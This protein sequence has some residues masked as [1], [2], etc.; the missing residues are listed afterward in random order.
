VHLTY[1][2]KGI[3]RKERFEERDR[4]RRLLPINS[5][6]VGNNHVSTKYENPIHKLEN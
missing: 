2:G 4:A 6:L 3:R 5:N 1:T